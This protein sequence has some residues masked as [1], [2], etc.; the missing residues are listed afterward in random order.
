MKEQ[1]FVADEIFEQWRSGQLGAQQA[2]G[3]L[4]SELGEV[5]SELTPL[6]KERSKLRDHLSYIVSLV[7][8]TKIPDFG[9]IQLTDPCVIKRYDRAALDSLIGRLIEDGY[10]PIA[11]QIAQCRREDMRAGSLRITREKAR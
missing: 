6:E 7:G 3:M 2:I 4:A 10:G 1:S 8:T 9:Q 11:Q 5:E